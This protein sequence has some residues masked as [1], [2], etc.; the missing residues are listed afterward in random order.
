MTEHLP[1]SG[2]NG[3]HGGQCVLM[4]LLMS[5]VT[6]GKRPFCAMGSRREGV[7]SSAV[8]GLLGEKASGTVARQ[9]ALVTCQFYTCGKPP[10]KSKLGKSGR[11][12]LKEASGL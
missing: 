12:L 8:H 9:V 5:G 11:S 1:G 6:R 4:L 7:T 10:R 2:G 3:A